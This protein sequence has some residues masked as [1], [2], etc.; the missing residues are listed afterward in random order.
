[1]ALGKKELAVLQ[2]QY[3]AEH[4]SI[5]EGSNGIAVTAKKAVMRVFKKQL[6]QYRL[7]EMLE[8]EDFGEAMVRL[9]ERAK[10]QP[11]DF[12]QVQVTVN[13]ELSDRIAA[14]AKKCRTRKI[15]YL[16]KLLGAKA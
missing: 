11:E 14:E 6:Q 4:Y 5:Q 3:P 8:G 12:L 9:L 13:K 10:L 1:M 7:K 15:I 2:K 16:Q